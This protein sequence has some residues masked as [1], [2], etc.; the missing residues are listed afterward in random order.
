MKLWYLFLSLFVFSFWNCDEFHL[1]FI[2]NTKENAAPADTLTDTLFVPRDSIVVPELYAL[3]DTLAKGSFML[4]SNS[5]L[6]FAFTPN[7]IDTVSILEL[8]G[9]IRATD[10]LVATLN[11]S[12]SKQTLTAGLQKSERD[13]F[14]EHV[15]NI[16]VLPENEYH[17]M[18]YD[19]EQKASELDYVLLIGYESEDSTKH[20][21]L[22]HTSLHEVMDVVDESELVL[23]PQSTKWVQVPVQ[24]GDSL[25]G[26]V[27]SVGDGVAFFIADSLSLD[28]YLFSGNIPASV[29]SNTVH[30][31]TIALLC[32]Q[33]EEYY[34]AVVNESA[35][36]VESS[37]SMKRR[38][39]VPLIAR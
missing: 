2:A 9:S 7:A 34:F 4:R 38:V 12:T 27:T 13:L 29:Y 18:I 17:F 16:L 5:Y 30:G 25:V 23:L 19:R 28:T 32:T 33:Q 1:A 6:S 36:T 24:P 20:D 3:N 22:A 15:A 10:T 14:I 11:N 26:S 21:I 31:D 37:W 39:Q 8:Y 35:D